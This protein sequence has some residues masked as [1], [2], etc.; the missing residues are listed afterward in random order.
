MQNG[1]ICTFTNKSL[2]QVDP[3]H[4]G[5]CLRRFTGDNEG[6]SLDIAGFLEQ[7]DSAHGKLPEI[8]CP[9]QGV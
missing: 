2:K 5:Q 4:T 1:P 3:F 7:N 6:L 8:V 9:A